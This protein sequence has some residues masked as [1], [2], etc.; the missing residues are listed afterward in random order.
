MSKFTPEEKARVSFLRG[1]A[2]NVVPVGEESQPSPDA[3]RA[4]QKAI[5]LDPTLSDAWCELACV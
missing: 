5:K 2:L 3:K 4:L 1:K